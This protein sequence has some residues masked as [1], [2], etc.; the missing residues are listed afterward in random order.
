MLNNK[1][2]RDLVVQVVVLAL[3]IGTI[4]LF[5]IIGV[6]N[7]QALGMSYGWGFLSRQAG[8]A[9]TSTWPF[10]QSVRATYLEFI[11]IGTA[12]TIRLSLVVIVFALLIGIPIGAA[13]LSRGPSAVAASIYIHT[14]RGPSLLLHVMFWYAA[15]RTFGLPR[16]VYEP[17]DW[18][19]LSNRGV[20]LP[21][22]SSDA[23]QTALIALGLC[24]LA[25]A[26][27]RMALRERLSDHPH[28]KLDFALASCAGTVLAVLLAVAVLH[29][30]EAFELPV[31]AGFRVVGGMAVSPEFF[32]FALAAIVYIANYVAEIVRQ[33]VQS[34]DR[35]LTEAATAL[36]LKPWQ[37]FVLVQMP[38]AM[39]N[40]LP[41]FT[42]LI[43]FIIKS[44]AA[45]TAVGYSELFTV[46]S[47]SINHTGHVLELLL[48]MCAIYLLIN[49][50]VTFAMN[51][52]N[53]KMKVP[54]R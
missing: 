33:G 48:I 42:N 14:V 12:N 35:G 27:A 50:A 29:G 54:T 3:F 17:G 26:G 20:F 25:V 40:M 37:V 43:T 44:T 41:P 6:R 38:L 23:A 30:S 49:T 8:I 7:I 4:A 45:A 10:E 22:L 24:V 9:L 1:Q 18:F 32:A 5:V 19:I 46:T 53:E 13:R 11:L 36:A 31:A 28:R 52:I 51:L 34:V 15:T 2:V 47:L 39:R 21:A 16:A